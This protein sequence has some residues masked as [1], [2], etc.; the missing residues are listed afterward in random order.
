M[1]IDI[2]AAGHIGGAGLAAGDRRVQPDTQLYVT[3]PL[4]AELRDRPAA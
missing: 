2:I 4:A 3:H 1:H